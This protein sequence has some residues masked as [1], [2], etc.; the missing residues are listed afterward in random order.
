MNR[1][2]ASPS[3]IAIEF[4]GEVAR[5]AAVQEL[6]LRLLANKTKSI[7]DSAHAFH[8][9]DTLQTV[10]GFFKDKKLLNE[11]DID[12]L[13][14]S[15]KIRNKILH[16][17][18]NVAIRHI[19]EL[20]GEKVPGRSISVFKINS[21]GSGGEIL[22]I[23]SSAIDGISSNK[24]SN[25]STMKDRDIGVFGGLLNATQTGAMTIAIEIF[26]K[27]NEIIER[28]INTEISD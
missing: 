11:H 4:F 25:A 17:E 18:F 15:Q 10:I 12:H 2:I 16:C 9:H 24:N 14:K 19:E 6:K 1:K 28:L 22:E 8:V 27:S 7:E 3:D 21:E 23:I 5:L 20:V 26:E 13:K